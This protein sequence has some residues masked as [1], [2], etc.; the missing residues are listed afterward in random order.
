MTVTCNEADSGVKAQLSWTLDTTCWR[1]NI[2]LMIRIKR[3]NIESEK[4][5]NNILLCIFYA[6]YVYGILQIKNIPMWWQKKRS[7]KYEIF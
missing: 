1:V 3:Y 2:F 6:R 5:T 4:L 7:S